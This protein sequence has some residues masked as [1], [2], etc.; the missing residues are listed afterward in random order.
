MSL[1]PESLLVTNK[2]MI[3]VKNISQNDLIL[4]EQG[5]FRKVEQID[6][7]NYSG[8]IYRIKTNHYNNELITTGDQLL[9]SCK[10]YKCKS[11]HA[12][13]RPE[14][15][16]QFMKR[17]GKLTP[18][19]KKGYKNYSY[20]LLPVDQLEAGDILSAPIFNETKKEKIMLDISD[21]KKFPECI[22]LTPEL[23]RLFG[24]YLS[25]GCAGPD[26]VIFTFHRKERQY[27]EDVLYL[28]EKY[29]GL[30]G[31]VHFPPKKN[32]SVIYV[33]SVNFTKFLEFFF[34]K[35]S[36]YKVIPDWC[37]YLDEQYLIEFFKGWAFGDGGF[38]IDTFAVT[39][40]NPEFIFKMGLILNKIGINPYTT[41][42]K[43]IVGNTAYRLTIGGLQLNVLREKIGI[44][45]PNKNMGVYINK[46]FYL[47]NGYLHFPIKT[48]E[49][50][51][52]SGEVFKIKTKDD[53]SYS[54]GY[55]LGR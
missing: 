22:E 10:A 47:E 46:Y 42:F 24:Y 41:F 7:K 54:I 16:H 6:T 17:N 5:E 11:D 28:C 19:C 34:G 1:H 18:N 39:T 25:E 21:I 12:F 14:C 27:V 2:G 4:T 31:T 52:Y 35:K 33:H 55:A 13:C 53:C 43:T 45:H 50:E 9:Y 26:R 51:N 48:I 37:L 8:D 15:K 23:M 49:K 20:E 40:I 36:K 44:S 29:F 3:A 30:K 38:K 32:S